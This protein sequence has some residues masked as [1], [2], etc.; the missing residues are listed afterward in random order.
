V[1]STEPDG[2]AWLVD[3]YDGDFSVTAVG[4]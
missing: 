2:P 1:L 3:A 4:S